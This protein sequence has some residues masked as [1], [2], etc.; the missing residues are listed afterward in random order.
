[1]NQLATYRNAG[2]PPN[3]TVSV[4]IQNDPINNGAQ[5][6]LRY[7]YESIGLYRCGVDVLDMLQA[8]FMLNVHAGKSMHICIEDCIPNRLAQLKFS[9][10]HSV[11]G[12]STGGA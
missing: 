8:M 6:I 5:N 10:V 1:M 2:S 7:N 9:E 11:Y 12:D 3:T 4:Q